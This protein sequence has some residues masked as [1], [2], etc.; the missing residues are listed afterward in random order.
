MAA[1]LK[2][3]GGY[4]VDA[5][6]AS[7][8]VSP[9]AA[10]KGKKKATAGGT[11]RIRLASHIDFPQRPTQR[12]A[13]ML[14]WV[15]D[16]ATQVRWWEERGLTGSTDDECLVSFFALRKQGDAPAKAASAA[17]K[18]PARSRGRKR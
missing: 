14:W 13:P 3:L 10:P 5:D 7:I 9:A 15:D 11:L 1:R 2:A 17:A 16:G 8:S 4:T 18:A 12:I 6:P